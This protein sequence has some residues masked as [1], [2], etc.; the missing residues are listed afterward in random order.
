MSCP[1]HGEY[2]FVHDTYAHPPGTSTRRSSVKTASVSGAC[3]SM[4]EH[5]TASND[6]SGNGRRPASPSRAVV[7]EAASSGPVSSA[8]SYSSET[9]SAPLARSASVYQ[10]G[11][12]PRSRMRR[13]RSD[14]WRASSASASSAA[15]NR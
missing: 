7:R 9:T 3:S 5:T 4:F 14:P 13:P 2:Q 6:A 11:P 8:R 10:P 12:Q 1:P 15:N